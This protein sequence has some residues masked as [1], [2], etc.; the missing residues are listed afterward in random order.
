MRIRQALILALIAVALLVGA[1]NDDDPTE[2]N[3]NA[4]NG[5]GDPDLTPPD[6]TNLT[7]SPADEST[8]VVVDLISCELTWSWVQDTPEDIASYRVL[9]GAFPP[10][11]APP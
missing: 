5:N 10:A 2:P 11:E 6:L 7:V 1:C 3:T 8:D 9:L 4:S